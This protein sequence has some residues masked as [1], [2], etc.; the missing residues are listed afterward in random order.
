MKA[1]QQTEEQVI[2]AVKAGL[3][4]YSAMDLEG[5]LAQYE[6]GPDMVVVGAGPGME[7]FGVE[8][9]RE[10]VLNDFDHQS[11]AG[12]KASRFRISREGDVAWCFARINA[13]AGRDGIP[14]M[15]GGRLTAV[16]VYKQGKWPIAQS[17]IS[18]PRHKQ[19]SGIEPTDL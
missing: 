1:D 17:H 5:V 16:L 8:A 6:E 3:N 13:F 18:F 10:A 4:A 14:S 7:Y 9:M 2:A 11:H 19:E 12:L 15:V